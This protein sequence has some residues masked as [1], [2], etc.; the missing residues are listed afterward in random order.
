MNEHSK[1]QKLISYQPYIL[2][3]QNLKKYIEDSQNEN[4]IEDINN[5]YPYIK[6]IN[7][8]EKKIEKLQKENELQKK[9]LSMIS[10][11]G[12]FNLSEI[13]N[14]K[15]KKS[16]SYARDYTGN[17]DN[18]YYNRNN[19]ISSPY[20]NYNKDKII[21]EDIKNLKR[22]YYNIKFTMEKKMKDLEKKQKINFEYLK[23]KLDG[24]SFTQK[25]KDIPKENLSFYV[26]KI[27]EQ[28]QNSFEEELRRKMRL[29]KAINNKIEESILEKYRNSSFK[30]NNNYNLNERTKF[31]LNEMLEEKRNKN[32]S[33]QLPLL[34][35]KYN[36]N[37]KSER[38][39][40]LEK[41]NNEILKRILELQKN[42]EMRRMK[43][44]L[45]EK[46]L[47]N[48]NYML[49]NYE[50]EIYNNNY[51]KRNYNNNY[52]P[53]SNEPYKRRKIIRESDESEESESS[54]REKKKYKKKKKKKISESEEN[55]N[56]E[57][58]SKNEYE[59]NLTTKTYIKTESS[60][61]N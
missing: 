22:S 53:R 55:S 41:K 4:P 19:N 1:N 16:F 13:G 46:R 36:L 57:S 24:N 18:N 8:L 37:N 29:E 17:D 54:E 43:K 23:N 12:K 44:N 56:S 58:Q 47:I 5:E 45:M 42:K 20:E 33:F 27:V 40:L 7:K 60:E 38:V 28:R 25:Y 30:E 31:L 9:Q 52:I 51:Y 34:N 35:N 21:R 59:S 26:K 39:L 10:S 61:S 15:L 14:K 11:N 3:K 32:N 50:N 48:N 49:N 2:R 6:K